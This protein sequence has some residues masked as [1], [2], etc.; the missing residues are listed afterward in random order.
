MLE[1]SRRETDKADEKSPMPKQ[2]WHWLVVFGIL[3]AAAVAAVV[4]TKLGPM[5][6]QAGPA[7]EQPAR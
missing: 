4:L 1:A 5:P 6:S 3:I 2:G 7:Q